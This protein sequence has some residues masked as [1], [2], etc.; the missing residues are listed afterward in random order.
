MELYRWQ[1]MT[2]CR[3]VWRHR[4]QIRLR[5]DVNDQI[6]SY[7]YVEEEVAMEQPSPVEKQFVS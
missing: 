3:E 4:R 2:A 1:V 5:S 6:H 7:G